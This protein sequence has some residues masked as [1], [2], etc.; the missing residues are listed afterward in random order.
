MSV[1]LG[2]S[3]FRTVVPLGRLLY[4]PLMPGST[5]HT[6]L[7]V[8]S[9]R[10]LPEGPSTSSVL[11]HTRYARAS[12]RAGAR[13]RAGGLRWGGGGGG[14]GWGG[15]GGPWWTGQIGGRGV[16]K[17]RGVGPKN[18]PRKQGADDD[19]ALLPAG[20]GPDDVAGLQVLRRAAAV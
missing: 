18:A 10:Y 8:S 5:S 12:S 4:V 3:N 14:G 11:C 17:A 15:A 6:A 16:V 9:T 2:A 13:G 20:G 19:R 7:P 1:A